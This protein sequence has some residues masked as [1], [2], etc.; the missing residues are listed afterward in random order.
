MLTSDGEQEHADNADNPVYLSI[1]RPG[2]DEQTDGKQERSVQRRDQTA[3]KSAN[4][5]RAEIRL[6]DLVDVQVV[7]RQ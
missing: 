6:D 2:E 4:A 3:L 1:A 5:V 7:H